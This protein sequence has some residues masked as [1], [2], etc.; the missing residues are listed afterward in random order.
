MD[1]ERQAQIRDEYAKSIEK[2]LI[3]PGSERIV[4]DDEHEII[5]EHPKSRYIS[6][7]M[8]PKESDISQEFE[9]QKN[10]SIDNSFEPNSIGM[11][12]NARMK[13]DRLI[14]HFK[15]SYYEE[16]KDPFLELTKDQIIDIQRKINSLE[17]ENIQDSLRF[18]ELN[19][20][21]HL[22]QSKKISKK[23]KID[24]LKKFEEIL[25]DSE[26]K[27]HFIIKKFISLFNRSTCFKRIPVK[28]KIEIEFTDKYVTQK[29]KINE[30]TGFEVFAK[31][32]ICSSNLS[33]VNTIT[34]VIKNIG[35]NHLF[36]SEVK[37]NNQF[38]IDFVSFEECQPK[39]D[40]DNLDKVAIEF[41]YRNKKSYAIGR[42][43]SVSWQPENNGPIEAIQ[44][45]YFPNYELLPMSFNIPSLPSK[46]LRLDTYVNSSD[47]ENVEYLTQFKML[48]ENWINKISKRIDDLDDSIKY[49]G[50]ENISKCQ[51]CLERINKTINILKNDKNAMDVF[52]MSSEAMILQRMS[53]M[54]EK[55]KSYITKNYSE[56]NFEWR[57]FQLAFILSSF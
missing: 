41:L 16:L 19:R 43:I 34:I 8:F 9:E 24:S 28:E 18:D 55:Q 32:D 46:I 56:V 3:G 23:N 57:P 35:S 10:L 20:T 15:T 50:K 36:Q 39:D 26:D 45:T 14:F 22:S 4:S 27:N 48:Y 13:S 30:N 29:Y 11:T 25:R 42:G 1:I 44:T 38:G 21:M 31:K 12:F 51:L 52:R 17:I 37:V 7:I 40:S 33:N 5:S 53:N 6:G 54:E 49:I 47:R 2:M